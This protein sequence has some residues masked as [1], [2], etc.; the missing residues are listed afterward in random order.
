MSAPSYREEMADLA[1]ELGLDDA[2]AKR[3]D[4]A[5]IQAAALALIGQGFTVAMTATA[6]GVPESTLRTWAKSDPAFGA[7]IERQREVK[8]AWLLGV[9]ELQVKEN[10][11]AASAAA[12]IL[13]NLWMP[14]LRRRE[15]D[16]TTT[17]GPDPERAQANLEVMLAR[18]K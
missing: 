4:R 13:A 6:L 11:K 15:L 17:G 12:N 1:R 10:G 8:R 9:L 3:L 7:A 2:Q 5:S 16:V 14:E 18:G